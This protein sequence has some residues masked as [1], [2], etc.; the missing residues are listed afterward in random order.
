LALLASEFPTP[1]AVAI[2]AVDLACPGDEV[3]WLAAGHRQELRLGVVRMP[4]LVSSLTQLARGGQD[5]VHRANSA[6]C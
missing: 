2:R 3:S 1:A 6:R 5:A 4:K